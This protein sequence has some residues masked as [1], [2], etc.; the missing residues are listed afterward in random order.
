MSD[1]K[2]ICKFALDNAESVLHEVLDLSSD[3]CDRCGMPKDGPDHRKC[4]VVPWINATLKYIQEARE[5]VGL[6]ET[7][8]NQVKE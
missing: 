2:S 6:K 7:N 4:C 1:P 8:P 3:N 5:Q